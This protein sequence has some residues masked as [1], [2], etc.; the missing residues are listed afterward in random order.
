MGHYLFFAVINRCIDQ[1]VDAV[2]HF[3]RGKGLVQVQG[4]Y[5]LMWEQRAIGNNT[6]MLVVCVYYAK[7][8]T[9]LQSEYLSLKLED[10]FRLQIY[11][12]P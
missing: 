8:L 3:L 6:H 5:I 11:T 7:V 4:Q 2:I 10:T 12:Q 1:P 9:A